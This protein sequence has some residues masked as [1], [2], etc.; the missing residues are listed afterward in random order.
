[1]WSEFR[2][3]W[4]L[5]RSFGTPKHNSHFWFWILWQIEGNLWWNNTLW[6]VLH[7]ENEHQMLYDKENGNDIEIWNKSS[8]SI[9]QFYS[10]TKQVLCFSAW[11]GIGSA[12]SKSSKTN[13]IWS[14]FWKTALLK[15][16]K[17][18]FSWA[19]HF[20]LFK[21]M[22]QSGTDYFGSKRYFFL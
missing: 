14:K 21:K 5:I 18:F 10:S 16:K 8:F 20:F 6:E 7:R 15:Y 2:W 22:Q 9:L 13:K 3:Q 4:L 12:C 11:N 19:L 1:M 17:F